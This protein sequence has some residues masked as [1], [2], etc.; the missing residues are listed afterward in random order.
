LRGGPNIGI[1]ATQDFEDIGRTEREA[2]TGNVFLDEFLRVDADDFAA[3]VEERAAAVTGVD[4]RVGLNPGAG[5]GVGKF[6]AR[7]RTKPR[8]RTR[9]SSK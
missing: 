4:R 2:D 3:G 6:P 8:K 1:E 7:S 5:P 9:N